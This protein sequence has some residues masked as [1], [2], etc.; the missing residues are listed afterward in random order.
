[1]NGRIRDLPMYAM[2]IVGSD[3]QVVSQY[4]KDG[5]Y[6][7]GMCERRPDSYA[8]AGKGVGPGL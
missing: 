2:Y 1:M 5:I 6:I 4:E 8:A 3:M 7:S